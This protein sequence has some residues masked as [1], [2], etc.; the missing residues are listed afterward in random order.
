MREA[1]FFLDAKFERLNDTTSARCVL[2]IL[3]I[4]AMY[5]FYLTV[6]CTNIERKLQSRGIPFRSFVT[7]A[8]MVAYQNER[9]TRA[10]V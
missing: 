8:V 9:H 7:S 2:Q 6:A 10:I 4:A 3:F 5:S 1:S